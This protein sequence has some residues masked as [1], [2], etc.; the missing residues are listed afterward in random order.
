[1]ETP[2]AATLVYINSGEMLLL[3]VCV[4]VCVCVCEGTF[5][6]NGAGLPLADGDST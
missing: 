5:H 1:M 4:C 2:R 6:E 3:C